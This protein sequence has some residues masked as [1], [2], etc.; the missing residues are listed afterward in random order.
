MIS[1]LLT[2][3]SLGLSHRSTAWTVVADSK[4]A[5]TVNVFDCHEHGI[6][7]HMPVPKEAQDQQ[8]GRRKIFPESRFIY[9]SRW[10]PY[11][12]PAGQTLTA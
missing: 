12:G 1:D 9:D 4:Y 2:T 5:T 6:T 3:L 8:E 7:D 10:D 11:N